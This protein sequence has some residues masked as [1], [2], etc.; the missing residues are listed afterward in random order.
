MK[1]FKIVYLIPLIVLFSG[2]FSELNVP[3][4]FSQSQ[5][6]FAN[7]DNYILFALRAEE[8]GDFTSAS[9]MF[10]TLWEKSQKR[11]YLYRSFRDELLTHNYKTILKRVDKSL[12]NTPN[13]TKLLRVKVFALIGLK[14]YKEAQKYALNLAEQT[15]KTDD[16][17][18]V[19]EILI[20]QQ[21]NQQA[22]DYL[23]KSYNINHNE[24][25]LDK[26]VLILYLKL[27]RKKDAIAYLQ[28]H[29]KTYGCSQ[30]ICKRLLSFY[31]EEKNL[32]G[33]LSILLRLYDLKN[34]NKIAKK[35]IQIYTYKK[36]YIKLMSF[37]EKS[38]ANDDILL[39]I[40]INFKNYKKASVLAQKLYDEHGNIQR[41]GESAIFEYESYKNKEDKQMQKRVID[42]L[43]RVVKLKKI[44]L[45]LNYL[46]YI[47]IDHSID[48]KEGINYVKEALKENGNSA[49]YLDSLAWGYYKLGE[50]KKASIII[51]KANKLEGG[52]DS[53]VLEHI[54]KIDRCK[55]GTK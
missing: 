45:Y 53:E 52:D 9:K 54:K 28:M 24:K 3:K 55:K 49:F 14:K 37:L 33:T 23:D 8:L 42:K 29:I 40:Y 7:E 1:I 50:C 5:K 16:H 10:T 48:I 51:H 36:D 39:Q 15:N 34:N 22:V 46:G 32:D 13:D 31:S 41:L 2:C 12:K 47:L 27:D 21:K 4:E 30:I 35:I 6:A 20:K 17:I 25:I 26:L 43:K 11:E 18:L 38:S 19:G 44:P